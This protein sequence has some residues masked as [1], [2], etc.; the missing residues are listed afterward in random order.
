M[1]A[2]FWSMDAIFAIVIF[3]LAIV[4][5]TYVWYDITNQFALASGYGVS[6]AQ[7]QLQA[8]QT[9][10]L[11]T[12]TPSDWYSTVEVSNT[13]SWSN[14]SIGLAGPGT[15]NLS[16]QKIFTLMAMSKSNY[17]ASKQEL[18]VGYDY[19]IT[20]TGSDFDLGIG[21]NPASQNATTEQVATLPVTISGR[22]AQ[23]QIIV[24]TNTTFGV[25]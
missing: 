8:L 13:L 24:W 22:S 12:G 15:A 6:S 3:S 5:M 25:A 20:I 9:R 19:Y 17:Q 11:G 10:L 18:G 21:S 14:V 23:M 2:Q 16:S 4:L 7:N 1:R